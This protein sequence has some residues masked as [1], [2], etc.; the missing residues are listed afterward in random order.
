MFIVH[1]SFVK[2]KIKNKKIFF[3]S[4]FLLKLCF[5]RTRAIDRPKLAIDRHPPSSSSSILL[6][7][8]KNFFSSFIFVSVFISFLFLFCFVLSFD[9]SFLFSL[10]LL[11]YLLKKK[12]KIC[13]WFLFLQNQGDRSPKTSDRS[14]LS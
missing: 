14:P 3:V 7:F 12:K 2:K 6:L 10:H 4:G 1:F 13:L 11:F 9:L 8:N 5:C